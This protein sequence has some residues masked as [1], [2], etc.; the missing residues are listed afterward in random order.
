M[1]LN[2]SNVDLKTSILYVAEIVERNAF[3]LFFSVNYNLRFFLSARQ[4]ARVNKRA[5]FA[6]PETI[7]RFARAFHA[8][9]VVNIYRTKRGYAINTRARQYISFASSTPR[10][11]ACRRH[12]SR[13]LPSLLR[14]Q[15]QSSSV[16]SWARTNNEAINLVLGSPKI[17]PIH[18][19]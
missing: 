16:S 6:L 12:L 5:L 17:L 2:R 13:S 11:H 18:R 1:H 8:G 3:T 4:S 10:A 19:I 14:R 9:P 7:I 15:K